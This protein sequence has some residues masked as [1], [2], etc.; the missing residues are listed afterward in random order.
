MMKNILS[1]LVLLPMF[2]F[3]YP[4]KENP[5][6]QKVINA[7]PVT[8]ST[9]VITQ[10][11][12][13]NHI[14]TGNYIGSYD[15]SENGYLR[16]Q[17]NI[18]EVAIDIL[19]DF[20]VYYNTGDYIDLNCYPAL[21]DMQLGQI[22]GQ[23][24]IETGFFAKI[25]NNR[26][27]I[28]SIDPNNYSYFTQFSLFFQ[29]DMN[30]VSYWYEDKD[31]DGYGN[32]NFTPLADCY[33]PSSNNSINY[34]SNNQDCD[35]DNAAITYQ[36]WYVDNDGDGY[37]STDYVDS[38]TNPGP[39]YAL[40][41]T[42]CDDTDP[43]VHLTA[44][45]ALDV[46]GD[47]ILSDLDGTPAYVN[48]CS[49]PNGNYIPVTDDQS[50][51]IHEAIFDLDGNVTG[52]SR[53]FFNDLGKSNVT[54]SKDFATN[55]IL[56]TETVYD[57][58][59]R[60]YISTF[61][62]P[63]IYTDFR[64]NKFFDSFNLSS[65]YSN[66]NTDEPFQDTAMQP[67]SQTNFDLLNPSNV[68]NT[69]GGN[70]ING[71]WLT[72]YSY[73]VPAAQEMYYV[74]G[75][76]YYEGT[77]SSGKE[78]VITKFF[79][80][81]SVDAN[82]VENVSFSDGEG[83]VLASAR[84]G[85]ATSYPVVSLIGTQGF[86]DVHI[87][88][89]ITSGQISLIGGSSLYSVFDLKTGTYATYP[90]TGGN[91]YRIKPFVTPGADPKTY[92]SGGVPT[93]DSGA[94][95]ITYAVNYYDYTVNI[96]NKTGQLIKSV[97]PNGFQLNSSVV[98]QPAHMSPSATNFIS[99][100]TYNDQGQLKQVVSPDEG[101]SKFLYRQDGQIRYS[102]SAL[103]ADA[104]VSYTDYDTYGR[105]I[106]SGV[107]ANNWAA[108][109]ANP[110]AALISG[111]RS[112]QTVTIY[113]YVDNNQT[114]VAIP[115]NLS[116][117]NLLSAEG[118]PAYSYVQHNLSGNVA[119]TFTNPD[120]NITAI[121]WYSYDIYGRTEWL[122]QYNEGLGTKTIHYNYDHK[123]N[124]SLVTFQKDKTA[125][126]F[127]HKYTYNANSVLTKV[128]TA[129]YGTAFIT[130]AD[131][132]YYQTG[133]LK[134]VNIAQ[135]LQGLDYVYTLGGQL[136][137]INHPSLEAAKDPGG[138]TNDVF[139]ITLDYY[140]GDYS[141]TGRNITTSPSLTSQDYNGNIKAVRW[142]NK[143][144]DT[145]SPEKAYK[146]NYN[147]N[148]WLTDATYGE[149]VPNTVAD[150]GS[151][152]KYKEAG[153]TYDANGNILTLQRTNELG[154]VQDNLIYN[155]K[156][157]KNQL[158]Q[159]ADA[160]GSSGNSNDIGSQSA[161][162]YGYNSIG[163]LEDN[164]S[165]NLHYIYNTQGLVSEVQNLGNTLVK[166][167]YNERGQRVKKESYSNGN[168]Q[169]T[170]Y[171]S[172]D[173]SG[174]TMAV[175]FKDVSGTLT[176]TDLPVFGL[177]R[178]G[179]YNRA[180]GI[181][182]YEITDHLGNVRAVIQRVG[183]NPQIQACAD[184]YPFGEKLIGRD[185]NSGYR[186]AFQGQELDP[187]TGMEA[188]QLRLWD[189]RIGRWL[190]P[191]PYQEFDSPY[192]GMGNNPISLT[193]PDGGSTEG[194][195]PDPP[196]TL[197]GGVLNEV[198]IYST[199]VAKP[200]D[201]GRDLSFIPKAPIFNF[202]IAPRASD[203]WWWNKLAYDGSRAAEYDGWRYKVNNDGFAMKG[204]GPVPQG[205][206]GALEFIGPGSGF[207][208]VTAYKNAISLFKGNKLLTNVGRAVTKHPQYFGFEST[209]ALM[210]V[211]RTPQALNN[212]GSST[213]KNIIRNGAKTTGAGGRYPNGWVT[214]T[215]QNGNA[216]SWG[217]DGAFIGFRGGL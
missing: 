144:L 108:A 207:K 206:A 53:T 36:R 45:W 217:A 75:S 43:S 181:A 78:E 51:W 137:S 131:Y 80:S 71:G 113:D 32:P 161:G 149:I 216:A 94:L 64:K 165:E 183:G 105:P 115:S 200:R 117:N 202:A 2:V 210:K 145:N 152:S 194:C 185:I 157:L 104:K 61:T 191:D 89:G 11:S 50:H 178:L 209:E 193:D 56:G 173:L 63:S 25:E 163:Q 155:Y 167:F 30:C 214:Y 100:Y 74:Y 8:T 126:Q 118:I 82:G 146:Y 103:Q 134:R 7:K 110:D 97:Q 47:G 48:S 58:F 93:Y 35:D 168:L 29:V 42:D 121:S 59:N 154:N 199:R 147:R 114:A 38:C 213:L 182:N 5:L 201:I 205:G 175:Y 77:I 6:F 196:V 150:I 162:N 26:F 60:P 15:G 12:D 172:L 158:D 166:F 87:P 176:Q 14:V 107:I 130:H 88:A 1:L 76:D 33:Q 141:R 106:E 160:A 180:S 198:V 70:T 190:S 68:I 101:T 22:Y 34:V 44:S 133:E 159:V 109:S 46:N 135:G 31:N 102:Q 17:N 116:L 99:T 3:G 169:N 91:A 18:F 83:K 211:H 73:K 55:K 13:F 62:A 81:V 9:N 138:D 204:L 132:S 208:I 57:G 85:G 20:G 192:L 197:N 16:M 127:I 40:N 92:I 142:K 188:F 174:N 96:Y 69:V 143:Y 28:F 203:D 151:L 140:N 119:V 128:E 72:G 24:G 52:A 54:L 215:L 153:L 177:S 123:G 10:Y 186:Y 49:K 66:S 120:A 67:Y 21:P 79:K 148:N 212:L 170:T 195:C 124:V 90:L 129:T 65:Y 41:N 184:Y 164:I 95:G 19:W 98:A 122:V 4:K 84:S 139:G 23:N 171:Y 136:K 112:E 179:V 125:E 27:I 189:G 37:G 187:E 111:A 156:S 39:Y 86:V